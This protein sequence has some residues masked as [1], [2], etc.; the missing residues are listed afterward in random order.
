MTDNVNQL[1]KDA[2]EQYVREILVAR[3]FVRAK[4]GD[5]E[6]KLAVVLGSGLGPL[7]K[8]SELE[9]KVVIPYGEIPH[10]PQSAVPGHAGE[11]ILA[12]FQGNQVLLMSGRTHYYES[13][14]IPGYNGSQA[15]R[16]ITLPVRV[17]KGLGIDALLLSNAAGGLDTSMTPPELMICESVINNSG[18]NPLSGLNVDLL[19]LRFPPMAGDECNNDLEK[20]LREAANELGINLRK[21]VYAMMSGPN[22]EFAGDCRALRKAGAHAV[23]MSTVSEI[24]AGLHGYYTADEYQT[25]VEEFKLQGGIVPEGAAYDLARRLKVIAVSLISNVIGEDGTNK[26]DHKEVVENGRKGAATFVPLVK[27]LITLY[28]HS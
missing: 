15:M 6:P 3:D 24:L 11:L 22:Y 16:H 1:M 20:Y 19:G 21:G 10:F 7:A 2:N 27:R 5:A 18:A 17:M 25:A 28:H 9:R 13:A 14:G 26:T 12:E 8:D 23:G 4:L